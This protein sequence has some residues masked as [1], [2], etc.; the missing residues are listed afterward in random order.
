MSTGFPVADVHEEGGETPGI[1]I[2]LGERE[3]DALMWTQF[4]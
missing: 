4:F 1:T 2:G 3:R